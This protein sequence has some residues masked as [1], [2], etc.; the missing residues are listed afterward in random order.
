[1]KVNK[2]SESP[3]RNSTKIKVRVLRVAGDIVE[4]K[5]EASNRTVRAFIGEHIRELSPGQIIE[6]EYSSNNAASGYV[7]YDDLIEIVEAEVLEAHH[8]IANGIMYTSIILENSKT[9]KRLHSLVQSTERM[10]Q[11]T[12]ILIKGDI[13]KLRLNN[14]VLFNVGV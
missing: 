5:H 13:V 7:V 6:V 2:N 14:G 10:F 4:C 9:H 3:N 8:I 12:S 11:D 1:M